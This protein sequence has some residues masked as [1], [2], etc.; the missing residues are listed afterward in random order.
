MFDLTLRQLIGKFKFAFIVLAILVPMAFA[1]CSSSSSVVEEQRAVNQQ[2]EAAQGRVPQPVMKN[3]LER[4]LMAELYKARDNAVATWSYIQ[5]PYTGKI[6]WQ[7]AS[8]GFPIPGGTQLTNPEQYYSSG[9][10]LPQAEPNGLYTPATSAGTYVMC[11]NKDGTI[12]PQYKEPAVETS[13]CPI[14]EVN[15]EVRCI[16][17]TKPSLKIDLSKNTGQ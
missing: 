14:E 13:M 16:E 10:V 11:V 17:G 15:G 9:G 6:L 5:S 12:S 8:I 1:A 4:Y 7:C 2:Q 3:Y